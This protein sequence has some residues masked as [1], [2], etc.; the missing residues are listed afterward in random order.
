MVFSFNAS[1]PPL[2]NLTSKPLSIKLL[3]PLQTRQ[4]DRL[5]LIN[6]FYMLQPLLCTIHFLP[7]HTRR[8]LSSAIHTTRR[9]GHDFNIVVFVFR[10]TLLL[11]N[12]AF[13]TFKFA[14]EVLY[15]AETVATCHS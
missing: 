12:F 2:L 7:I 10:S 9:A 5:S 6:L 8:K 14:D 11:D 3:H 4:L 13:F 1:F 15:I